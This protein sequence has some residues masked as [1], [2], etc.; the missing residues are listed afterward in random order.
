MKGNPFSSTRLSAKLEERLQREGKVVREREKGGERKR[1]ERASSRIRANWRDNYGEHPVETE[2]KI[3][4]PSC[5]GKL[6]SRR[7][8]AISGVDYMTNL[9][10]Y[11]CNS[12]TL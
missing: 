12:R 9:C 1:D 10:T 8:R 5:E 6:I 3:H 4:E 7:E 11:V 2:G